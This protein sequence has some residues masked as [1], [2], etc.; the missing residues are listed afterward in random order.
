MV[1]SQLLCETKTEQGKH[2][3]SQF[4]THSLVWV[5]HL[6]QLFPVKITFSKKPKI[7]SQDFR[8]SSLSLEKV[9]LLG[10]DVGQPL[11]VSQPKNSNI[12]N[13]ALI[14]HNVQ[15]L[16]IF[17]R[18]YHFSEGLSRDFLDNAS[19]PSIFSQN[20]VNKSCESL[21]LVF[22]LQHLHSLNY[23]H[24]V[25]KWSFYQV[26]FCDQGGC[27]DYYYYYF[28]LL[29]SPP[30]LFNNL[31]L[32]V[33]RDT[34]SAYYYWRALQYYSKRLLYGFTGYLFV[35]PF[36]ISSRLSYL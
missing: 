11:R 29:R 18:K 8:T 33:S 32:R 15:R 10:G 34:E 35:F 21:R 31:I 17:Y 23:I 5:Q 22:F 14:V 3:S 25:C 19:S 26:L 4:E 6:Q 20:L 30:I 2:V 1:T 27:N 9:I 13:G 36:K 7:R 24:Q 28:F 12:S 16:K